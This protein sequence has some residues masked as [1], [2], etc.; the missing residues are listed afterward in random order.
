MKSVEMELRRE[1]RCF[2]SAFIWA[3]QIYLDIHKICL[4]NVVDRDIEYYDL[5]FQC[6]R[7]DVDRVNFHMDFVL[8][9]EKQKETKTNMQI[10]DE[11]NETFDIDN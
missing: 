6:K 11:K 3:F 9:E 7:P 10:D 2:S 5:I 8:N 4:Y 1:K